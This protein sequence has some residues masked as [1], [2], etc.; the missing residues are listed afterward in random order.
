MYSSSSAQMISLCQSV[1]GL[2]NRSK[3]RQREREE[4]N[5]AL[6]YPLFQSSC[7]FSSS[8]S[9]SLSLCLFISLFHALLKVSSPLSLSLSRTGYSSLFC[10]Y[11][12]FN[13]LPFYAV[14]SSPSLSLIIFSTSLSL[15]DL[16]L[17]FFMYHCLAL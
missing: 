4:L 7:S 14:L 8:L 13:I 6:H 15:L 12:L 16:S 3:T 1:E 10:L 11:L 2:S 5:S 17:F 9:L